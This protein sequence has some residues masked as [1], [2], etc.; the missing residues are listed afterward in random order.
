[1]DISFMRRGIKLPTRAPSGAAEKMVPPKQVVLLLRQEVGRSC[2]PV[3]KVGDAVKAGQQIADGAESGAADLHASISG[4]V[5]AFTEVL[6]SDGTEEKA[7]VIEGDGGGGVQPATKISKPLSAEPAELLERIRQAGIICASREA[8]SLCAVIDEAMSPRGYLNPTGEAIAKPIRHIAVR[9]CDTDPLVCSLRA[10][11]GQIGKNTTALKLGID[12]LLKITSAEEVHFALDKTQ[13][14]AAVEKLADENDIAVHRFDACQY[15][16]F[17]DPLIA[18]AVL[19]KEPEVAYKRIHESG[20]LV[21]DIDTVLETAAALKSG[22]PVTHK[23]IAAVSSTGIKAVTAPIGTSLEAIAEIAAQGLS[24]DKVILGGPMQGMAHFTL[25][26][27]MSK[28]TTALTL[29]RREDHT[30]AQNDPCICCGLCSEVCPTRLTPGMLSRLC[31][32][33]E[34]AQAEEAHL[35][36][37]IECGCCAYV[38][39]AGRSMVQFMVQG[40][41]ERLAARRSD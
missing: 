21:L 22:T 33:K 18:A 15:P 36:S 27:P 41:S 38:C 39:P 34:F 20:V 26:F 5:K 29:L 11:A 12:A 17:S 25:D 10:V 35:F 40:K 2:K 24:P 16:S 19:G 4:E 37:C 1:M 3:V 9:F 14:L 13:E 8:K 23:T 7:I 30:K 32:F 31:E 6:L 28:S